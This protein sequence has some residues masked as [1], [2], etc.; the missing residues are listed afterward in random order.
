MNRPFAWYFVFCVLKVVAAV[1]ALYELSAAST[2]QDL[3]P[4][5][6]A[7]LSIGGILNDS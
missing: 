1:P 7:G 2:K 4:R 3:R 5:V 6:V